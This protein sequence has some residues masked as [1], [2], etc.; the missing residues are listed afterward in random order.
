ML[1]GAFS[2]PPEVKRAILLSLVSCF[3]I[4]SFLSCAHLPRLE[5][6]MTESWPEKNW[7]EIIESHRVLPPEKV[8][9]I[10]RR[11]EKKAGRTG[12]L[13]LQT[14]VMKELSA[15]PLVEGNKATLLVDGPATYAAMEKAIESAR[16]HIN[17]E[18]FIFA[19]DEEGRRFADLL[20]RKQ[21]EGVQVNLIYDSVGCANTPAAFFKRFRAGGIQTLEV[22]P[23]EAGHWSAASEGLSR[24]HRKILIVDGKVAFTGGVNISGEYSTSSFGLYREKGKKMPWR[25]TDVKIEGPVVAEF[26]KL[27]LEMWKRQEGPS[28]AQRNYFP[29]LNAIGHDLVRVVGSEPGEKNRLTYLM[30]V[31]AI[32]FASKSVHLTSAYFAPDEQTRKAFQNVARRGVDVKLILPSTSDISLVFY[33]G[34]SYYE[35]LLESGVKVYERRDAM[36]HAKTAVIDDVWST[37]GSTNMDLWSFLRDYEVNAIILG[38]DFA[39]QMEALFSKDLQASNEIV[40]EKWKR[41]SLCERLKESF[42]RLIRYWL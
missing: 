6:A 10:I 7:P 38:P 14:S 21:A 4:F 27:F 17:F 8:D 3:C 34:R 15:L 26:Q 40:P 37:I 33:A 32:A 23:V 42:A 1:K 18:T 12:I 30:Y 22:N 13:E 24:D 35:D 28:L 19:D 11:L 5:E 36:L 9:A 25:D 41:R 29:A 31:S 39:A 16:D 20:L 2:F